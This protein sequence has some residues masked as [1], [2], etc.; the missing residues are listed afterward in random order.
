MAP[1]DAVALTHGPQNTHPEFPPTPQ[2]PQRGVQGLQ[3]VATSDS[4]PSTKPD[5]AR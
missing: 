5:R 4:L 2:Q 1:A 3:T